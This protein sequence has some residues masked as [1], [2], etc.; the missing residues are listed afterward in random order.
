MKASAARRKSRAQIQEEK[1]QEQQREVQIA[2]KMAELQQMQQQADQVNATKAH[3]EQLFKDGF[4]FRDD[5]G[6]VVMPESEEMRQQVA[7]SARKPHDGSQ[8]HTAFVFES[9]S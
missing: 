2:A 6:D 8:Q 1:L 4:L 7:E 5:N 9:P 3:V